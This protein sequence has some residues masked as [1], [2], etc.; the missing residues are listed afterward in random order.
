M[1]FSSTS[2][3]FEAA[4]RILRRMS[5]SSR[6]ALSAISS[7]PMMHA[8]MR[9]CRLGLV[10]RVLKKLSRQVPTPDDLLRQSRTPLMTLSARAMLSSSE[11]F[12]PPPASA[13]RRALVMLSMPPKDGAPKRPMSICASSVCFCSSSTRS[14]VTSGSISRAR[15]PASGMEVSSARSCSTLS[16]SSVL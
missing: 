8:V 3:A 9:S 2:R 1:I 12:S 10:Y 14:R 15:S 13:R 5:A 6:E 4:T 7:A 11:V 16:S